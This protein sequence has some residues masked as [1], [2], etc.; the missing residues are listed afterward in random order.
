MTTYYSK[1]RVEIANGAT[2]FGV[3]DK[4]GRAVGYRWRIFATTYTE[5]PEARGG[6]LPPFKPFELWTSP[7]RNGENYGP[8][9]NNAP[10]ATVAE[11]EAVIAKRTEAARKRETKR[12]TPS[13]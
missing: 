3:C 9:F 8:A 1:T 5:V 4:K 11:A 7:T 13:S 2:E 12:F 6:Y 10:A